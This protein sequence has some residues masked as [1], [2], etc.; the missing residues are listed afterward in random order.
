MSTHSGLI[1]W[2]WG[3]GEDWGEI[4]CPDSVSVSTD[5]AW[6]GGEDDALS[7]QCCYNIEP[8]EPLIAG[9]QICRVWPRL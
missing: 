9:L 3:K 8:L 4:M 7:L 5:K 2:G 1:E 6:V